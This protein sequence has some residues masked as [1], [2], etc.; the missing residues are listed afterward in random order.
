M[1]F[2]APCG[3]NSDHHRRPSIFPIRCC[4]KS[5]LDIKQVLLSFFPSWAMLQVR[6]NLLLLLLLLGV[7]ISNAWVVLPNT[8]AATTS[9]RAASRSSGRTSIKNLPLQ[10]VQLYSNKDDDDGWDDDESSVLT[11]IVP[12]KEVQPKKDPDMFIPIF[13][14]V[15]ILGLFGSYGYEMMRLASRGEL[16]LPWNN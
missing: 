12:P 7:S 10:S 13:S 9:R 2:A 6:I 14:L 11:P 3:S 4:S 1:N 16:Y 8:V 5:N 15:S